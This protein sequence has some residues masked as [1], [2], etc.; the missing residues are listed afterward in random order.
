MRVLTLALLFIVTAS[1]AIAGQVSP[2][3]SATALEESAIDNSKK[4]TATKVLTAPATLT[5]GGVPGTNGRNAS[6]AVQVIL[7]ASVKEKVGTAAFGW[8]TGRQQWQLALSGP[9]DN[10]GEA[11]PTSLTGLTSGAKAKLSVSRLLWRTPNPVERRQAVELCQR[12]GM[13]PKPSGQRGEYTDDDFKRAQE[14]PE[15][16]D[17]NIETAEDKALYEFYAHA[18]ARPWLLGFD[19]TAG[20]ATQ[21]FVDK[22][23]L[24]SATEKNIDWTLAARAGVYQQGVGFF[25]VSYNYVDVTKAAGSPIQICRPLTDVTLAGATRCDNV[26]VGAPTPKVTSVISAELR[27]LISGKFAVSPSVIFDLKETVDSK[28]VWGIDV[29]VYF[30]TTSGV[31]SPTGGVRFGWR[32]DTKEVTAVIFIGGAF[33][34]FG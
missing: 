26:I 32:S 34:L 23:T 13:L 33:K 30:L 6:T 19:A 18:K 9:L 29:P 10:S 25:L 7:D 4:E 27:Q 28:R 16:S 14:M 3:A 12:L 17:R 22:S 20:Q 8:A 11:T 31:T 2:G 21:K 15:C 24:A 1:V 5:F